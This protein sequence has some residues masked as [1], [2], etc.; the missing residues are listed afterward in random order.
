MNPAM[1]T[2]PCPVL[3]IGGGPAGLAAALECRRLGIEGV[4]LIEREDEA[5]GVP[6]MCHHTGF[7]LRDLHRMFSGPAY[8]RAY[9]TRVTDAGVALTSSAMVTDWTGPRTVA[10]TNPQGLSR[11]QAHAVLLATGCRERPQAARLIPGNRPLGVF[12]TGSLQRFVYEHGERVGRHAVVVGAELISL[13]C[14]LTLLHAGTSVAMMVTEHPAHQIYSPYLPMLWYAK[15]RLRVKVATQTHLSRIIGAKRVEAVEL[16]HLATGQVS[17]VSCDTVVFTGSWIPEHELA[18]LGGLAIDASTR[19]PQVDANL[20]TSAE[21]VFAAGNLVHGAVTADRAALEGRHAA[22][23]IVRYLQNREW[24]QI[25]IPLQTEL[26]IAWV[27]PTCVTSRQDQP[28][29][30]GFLFQVNQFCRDTHLHIHQDNRLLHRQTFHH[31]GPNQ[32]YWL[33]SRWLS[34][35]DQTGGSVHLTLQ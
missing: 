35:L 30:R 3:I 13:S 8:A 21:G 34:L 11:I 9:R 1:N 18:R 32:S 27:S 19:G 33:T 22:R 6:R 14:V 26:P 29:H 5:G 4:R 15:R 20:H 2:D 31:L 10:V 12:T 24:P 25:A 28:P 23:S 17:T 7:G 16:A